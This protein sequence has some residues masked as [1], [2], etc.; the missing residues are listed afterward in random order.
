MIKILMMKWSLFFKEKMKAAAV[1]AALMIAI[2]SS[3]VLEKYLLKVNS[4]KVSSIY[5]DRL[6]P[7][8]DLYQMRTMNEQRLLILN[9][10]YNADSGGKDLEVLEKLVALQHDFDSLFQKYEATFLEKEELLLAADLRKY[11]ILFNKSL[12]SLFS[13]NSQKSNYYNKSI[14]HL[15]NM[16]RILGALNKEQGNIGLKL[17]GEYKSDNSYSEILNYFQIVIAILFGIIIL[18]MVASARLLYAYDKNINL[19]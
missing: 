18:K 12:K 17:L 5:L 16:N 3:N 8:T 15:S 19:N 4:E 1:L 10:L 7:S 6:E 2:I 9:D 14:E 13:A 11:E